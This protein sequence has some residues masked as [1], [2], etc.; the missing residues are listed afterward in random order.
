MDFLVLRHLCQLVPLPTTVKTVEQ[1]QPLLFPGIEIVRRLARTILFNGN[2]N[3]VRIK[4]I[5]ENEVNGFPRP[6]VGRNEG[7][8]GLVVQAGFSGNFPGVRED[9]ALSV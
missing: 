4:W 3:I 5:D 1:E 6:V 7:M 9:Q 8:I 2:D